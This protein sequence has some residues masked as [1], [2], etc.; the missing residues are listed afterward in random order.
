[1]D[2]RHVML[3]FHHVVKNQALRFAD[4]VVADD[5]LLCWHWHLAQVN[6]LDMVPHV[7]NAVEG[8]CSL[9]VGKPLVSDAN[10]ASGLIA[11][12]RKFIRHWKGGGSRKF[13]LEPWGRPRLASLKLLSGRERVHEVDGRDLSSDDGSRTKVLREIAE[14]LL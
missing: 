7:R 3:E 8:A 4:R 14:D 12:E 10:D 9:L 13:F 1:M 5:P 6:F 2:C 11:D